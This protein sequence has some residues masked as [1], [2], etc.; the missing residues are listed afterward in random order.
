MKFFTVYK[1]PHAPNEEC[2]L[3]QTGFSLRHF[4]FGIF[5]A[6]YKGLWDLALVHLLLIS[7]VVSSL[8]YFPILAPEIFVI[9]VAIQVILSFYVVPCFIENKLINGGYQEIDLVAA[10]SYEEAFLRFL[11]AAKKT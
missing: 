10:Y 8:A 4:F 11:D 9:A 5:W 6:I 2:I 1:K 7:V 3:V